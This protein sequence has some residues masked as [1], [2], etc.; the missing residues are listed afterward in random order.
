MRK[1]SLTRRHAIAIIAFGIIIGSGTYALFVSGQPN[2]LQANPSPPATQ[3]QAIENKPPLE[4]QE[5]TPA[6]TSIKTTN[7]CVH[8]YRQSGS[9]GEADISDQTIDVSCD[10]KNNS[11]QTS[12]NI[13]SDSSQ[14]ASSGDSS[15][16]QT[17][18]TSVSNNS[19]IDISIH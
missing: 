17:G 15:S 19:S 2:H 1:L 5:T 12:V 11:S 4:K 13:T 16:G 3:T 18:S 14:T 9:D 6:K 8:S 7:N 10:A